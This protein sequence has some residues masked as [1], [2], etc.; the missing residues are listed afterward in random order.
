MA[1]INLRN[2]SITF[3]EDSIGGRDSNEI[4]EISSLDNTAINQEAE[5]EGTVVSECVGSNCDS[6][7]TTEVSVGM[8]TRQLQDLL[9]NAGI[10]TLRTDIVTIIDTNNLK[11]QVECL[12]LR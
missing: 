6:I 11:F 5:K 12:N 10:S 4:D 1:G 9:T 3:V 2:R 7:V 8:S